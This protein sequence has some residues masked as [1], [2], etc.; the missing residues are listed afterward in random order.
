MSSWQAVH[1]LIARVGPALDLQQ[2]IE[3][4]EDRSWHLVFDASTTIDV[5]YDEG[6]DRLMLTANVAALA[7]DAREKSFGA[8]L[9][10]NYLWTEHGGVRAAL[11]GSPGN[12][13]LMIETP[14]SGLE[15]S[16]L[17]NILQNFRNV[18]E[19]WRVVLASIASGGAVSNAPFASEGMIRV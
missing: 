6:G 16:R 7:A 12:V 17:C 18:V 3:F 11:D 13:V 2:V 10:Y 1:D 5:D 19:G 14:A 4:T 8:L 9:R 15:I